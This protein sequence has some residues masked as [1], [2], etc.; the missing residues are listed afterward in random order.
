M[1]VIPIVPVQGGKVIDIY[2]DNGLKP[3]NVSHD[4]YTVMNH[5]GNVY[6]TTL[7]LD[8]DALFKRKQQ[9]E[10][11]KEL[12]EVNEVWVEPAV[13]RSEGIIDPLVA[14][15]E[16]VVIGTSTL[17][18][19]DELEEAAELSDRVIPAIQWNNGEVLRRYPTKHHGVDD[20]RFHLDFFRKL[21]LESIMFMD[22]GRINKREGLDPAI[23]EIVMGSG[24]NAY[25]GGGIKEQDTLTFTGL[26]AAGILL[27]INDLLEQISRM[28][29]R[30][31][32]VQP[33]EVTDYEPAIQLNP[34]GFPEFH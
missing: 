28:R 24:M 16:W 1:K 9:I 20:I 33:H 6:D 30:R 32:V 14:G 31:V 26:G 17:D 18:S 19:L 5:L 13:R 25:F 34:L 3:G 7:F 11:L 12:S 29:P 23:I 10:V 2:Y 22:L 27:Y 15:G 4:I 21:D 8:L